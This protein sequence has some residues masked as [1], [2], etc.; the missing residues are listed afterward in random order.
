M[1]S[2]IY[3]PKSQVRN[4]IFL[5][6]EMFADVVKAND[7]SRRLAIRDIKALYRQSLLG[8]LW[9]FLLPLLNTITWLFLRESGIVTLADTGMSYTVFVISGT[10]L[11]QIFAEAL[12]SPITEVNA[13]KGVMSKL[14]F[15]REAIIV[16][17]FYKVVFN[18]GIKLLILIPLVLLLGASLSWTIFL[19]PLAVL[20]LILLGIT[21][22]LILTP[23]S[24]LYTDIAK[25]LPIVTQFLMFLSPVVFAMPRA[26]FAE[27]LFR[28]NFISPY[29]V[30]AR[31]WLTGTP[32]SALPFYLLVLAIM[33]VALLLA[34]V[35]YR[36]AMPIL[37]ERMSS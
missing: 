8:Y 26:G 31:A 12:Q 7:L 24:V 18:A 17:G 4:P 20:S 3:S 33:V 21:L 15:P 29:I 30:T 36:V 25:G 2:V 23:I 28:Y 35:V 22:G 34:W 11:W 13:A 37:V 1:Q 19:F 5:L 14:N 16:S 10:M 9:A 32:N 27:V 6:K